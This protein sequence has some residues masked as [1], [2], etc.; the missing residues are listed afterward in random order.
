MQANQT[1][2]DKLD[3]VIRCLNKLADLGVLY[4]ARIKTPVV[5]ITRGENNVY[6]WYGHSK[7]SRPSTA[8]R[9]KFLRRRF[10]VD[11]SKLR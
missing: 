9:D 6:V 3:E 5:K 8:S 11:L 4:G 10:V 7:A 2:Q 1:E